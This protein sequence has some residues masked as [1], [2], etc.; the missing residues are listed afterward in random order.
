M[1]ATALFAVPGCLDTPYY[2]KGQVN[3]P[4]MTEKGCEGTSYFQAKWY[5]SREEAIGGSG[6][7][8]GGCG[9]Y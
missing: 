8:G 9:C 3:D 1:A 2:Q 6:V 7:S 4:L 5:Y